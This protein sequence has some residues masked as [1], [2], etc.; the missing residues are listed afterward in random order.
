MIDGQPGQKRADH[1]RDAENAGDEAESVQA[2]DDLRPGDEALFAVSFHRDD[3]S[4]AIMTPP[5]TDLDGL[6][7]VSCLGINDNDRLQQ[8]RAP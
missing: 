5:G 6:R 4:R 2:I 7:F 3:T 8:T 1:R